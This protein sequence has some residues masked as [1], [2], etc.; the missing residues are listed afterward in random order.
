MLET[1]RQFGEDQLAASGAGDV[2]RDAHARYFA[3]QEPVVS[4][5]WAGP[6]HRD[7]NEWLERELA[8]LRAGFRWA[9][10]RGDLD[11]AAAIAITGTVVGESVM[12]YEPILWAEEL[13]APAP[14]GAG[15]GG[16][17]CGSAQRCVSS[18]VAQAGCL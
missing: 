14:R 5:L 8:N 16:N 15:H 12:M 10:D 13:L 11:I 1:I 6:G 7:A 2:T 3:A 9:V 18:V 17:C 4:G